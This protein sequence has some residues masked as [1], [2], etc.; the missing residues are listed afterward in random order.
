MLWQPVQ[1]NMFRHVLQ[2]PVW[3]F[4]R[5]MMGQ[6]GYQNLYFENSTHKY[7][8]REHMQVLIKK[9]KKS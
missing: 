3:C 9:K 4:L 2:F 6:M 1:W 5:Q 7:F 8:T